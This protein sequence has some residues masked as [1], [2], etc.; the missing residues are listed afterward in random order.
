M[1]IKFKDKDI[2]VRIWGDNKTAIGIYKQDNNTDYFIYLGESFSEYFEGLSQFG[3]Y[4]LGTH[5][6]KYRYPTPEE[7]QNLTILLKNN[8]Y[9]KYI[10]YIKD[11]NVKLRKEKLKKLNEKN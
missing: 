11:V 1:E 3:E 9:I 8:K 10:K 4:S 2:I 6:Y 7:V 5:K